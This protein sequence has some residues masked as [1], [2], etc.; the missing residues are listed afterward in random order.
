MIRCLYKG[1]Q[2]PAEPSGGRT[3]VLRASGIVKSFGHVEA[4]REAAFEVYPGEITALIG[5]NGAGKS[6][7]VKVLSGVM[8]PDGGTIEVDGSPVQFGSPQDAAGH[9]IGTVYQD[10]ALAPDLSPAANFFI[11][12]ELLRPG[13]LG[14]LGWLDAGAMN[15]RTAEELQ[16]LGVELKDLNAPVA[17]LSGGQRQSVAIC[18]AVAWAE[19][20]VFMDEPTAALGVVQT[21]RVMRLITRVREQG[22]AVVLISHN[23]P[24]VI[25][26]ADRVQVLRLGSRVA[27]YERGQADEHLLVAAMTGAVNQEVR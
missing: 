2:V 24:Q 26:L 25:E 15:R 23:M 7:L 8:Q 4:L 1:V 13:L 20:V 22:V 12:R 14:R 3:P 11:G 5:D 17:S 21:E 18:R 27:T 9:G 19:R 16:R 6:T 10:L